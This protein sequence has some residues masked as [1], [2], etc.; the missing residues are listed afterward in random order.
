MKEHEVPTHVQAEDRVLLWFTFPQ[1]V[2]VTAVCALSYG[3]Y[4]YVP[5][6]AEARLVLA[7]LI[8]LAGI[9]MIVAKVGGR[10]LPL[11]AADLLRY[12]LSARLH[13]GTVCQLVRSE[14]SVRTRAPE[15][16]LGALRLI[17]DHVMRLLSGVRLAVRRA[18]RRLRRKK[19][20]VETER[21]NGRVPF[22]PWGRLGKR[23]RATPE[24]ERVSDNAD[25]GRGSR[26]EKPLKGL[27]A[28]VV[29]VAITTATA[30][31]GAA[32]ADKYWQDEIGFELQEPVTGRRVYVE[33]LT[34]SG[35]RAVVTIRAATDIDIRI[36]AFGGP[37]GDTPMFWGMAALAQG[38]RI[39]YS[40][41]LDGP[42]PSF[43]FAWK[44]SA[45]QAGAIVVDH[46]RIPYPLPEAEGDL[47]DVRLVSLGWA[48]GAVS[49]VVESECVSRVVH[50]VD[51]Q[52]VAGHEGVAETAL[53]DAEVTTVTGTITAVTGANEASVPLVPN[54]QTH[55]RVSVPTGVALHPIAVGIELEASL[56]IAMP[57]LVRLTH[58]PER[59]ERLTEAVSLYR[60]GTSE[61]VSETVSVANSDG[62]TTWYTISATVSVP[63]EWVEREV[64]FT[65]VHTER[66]EAEVTAREP[67]GGTRRESLSME[68]GVG[69]D[70]PFRLLFLPEPA[71]AEHL[72]EQE[73]L[74]SPQGWEPPK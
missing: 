1:V 5:G 19:R 53:M 64:T 23:R 11:V 56:R 17:T 69:S 33:T 22:G 32:L 34:V 47:C 48:P 51:L 74:G 10:R 38:E 42:E 36:R 6:P 12:R 27:L 62:T 58:H 28:A 15:A 8:A 46:E 52:I 29:F 66:I 67:V 71:P 20:R 4:R 3:V 54:G 41:P 44:D 9:A 50:P 61:S 24:T 25:A 49:G 55:F 13:A 31:P 59:T 72:G 37:G 45:R 21:Q 39:D 14:P 73:H 26:R 30:V 18:R 63:G 16:G 2:A 7:V 43:T 57:P 35:E 40:L 65:T 70:A 68:S 60:P